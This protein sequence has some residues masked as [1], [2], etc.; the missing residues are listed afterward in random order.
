MTSYTDALSASDLIAFIANDRLE[1]SFDKAQYQFTAT[2][3]ICADWLAA[4]Y[5]QGQQSDLIGR[6]ARDLLAQH[7][8]EPAVYPIGD[9]TDDPAGVAGTSRDRRVVT[10]AARIATLEARLGL[11]DEEARLTDDEPQGPSFV[12]LRDDF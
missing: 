4:R 12:G 11:L 6:R 5:Q 7:D 1:L 10:M 9:A 3:R 2:K 8:T